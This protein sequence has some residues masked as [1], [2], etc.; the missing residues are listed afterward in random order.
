MDIQAWLGAVGS[1]LVQIPWPAWLLLGAGIVAVYAL[2]AFMQNTKHAKA[3]TAC[4]LAGV[5]LVIAGVA[6]AMF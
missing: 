1:R 2:P 5:A 6:A 3:I 4:K